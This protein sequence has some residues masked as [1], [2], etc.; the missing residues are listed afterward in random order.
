[1]ICAAVELPGQTQ[2]NTLS[3]LKD[4]R[5][6]EA[7]TKA[8]LCRVHTQALGP[9]K[10]LTLKPLYEWFT[11][12]LDNENLSFHIISSTFYINRDGPI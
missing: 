10:Y 7:E 4:W 5:K 9:S 11:Q 3:S 6:Q 2:L 12:L 8:I 1:M